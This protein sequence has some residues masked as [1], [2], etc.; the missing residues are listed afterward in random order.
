M[1]YECG[2]ILVDNRDRYKSAVEAWE[3]TVD[4]DGGNTLW[5]AC[6]I[7]R[8]ISLLIRDV[9]QSAN[10]VGETSW[11]ITPDTLAKL[12][13]CLFDKIVESGQTKVAV[14]Y[15]LRSNASDESYGESLSMVTVDGVLLSTENN[16]LIRVDSDDGGFDRCTD[17]ELIAVPLPTN[18]A[19]Y[20]TVLDF[21]KSINMCYHMDMSNKYLFFYESY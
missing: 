16:T 7:G 4:I 15:A 1:G 14:K 10:A 21:A 20:S 12:R 3:D 8:G 2:L 17:Y 5:Y 18:G 6:S 9:L 11:E 13:D 19:D